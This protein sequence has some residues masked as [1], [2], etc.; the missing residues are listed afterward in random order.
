MA[1]GFRQFAT[2]GTILTRTDFGEADRILT[3]ITPDHGKIKAIAKGVRKSNAKLAGAVELFSVSDITV[4]IG[5]GEI[6]TLISARLAHHYGNI[7]KDLER[8]EVGF[9]VIRILN[10]S[11]EDATEADYFHLLKSAF[12]ALDDTSLSP[13]LSMLW[14]QMQLL[15]LSGHSPNLKTDISGIK[16]KEAATYDF[17]LDAMRF[18]PKEAEKGSFSAKHIK[19]LRLGFRSSRP[20]ILERVEGAAELVAQSQPL[21]Q[22]MLKSF[23]RI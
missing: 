20:Q 7:I 8:T 1:Q 17:Y 23:V 10:K 16:L 12:A 5:R 22:T 18:S 15:K 11:T 19:F 6:N 4:V 14:F 13:P 9:E 3:F 21:I 2:Q